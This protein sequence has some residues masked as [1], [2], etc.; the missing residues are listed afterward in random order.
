MLNEVVRFL[1]IKTLVIKKKYYELRLIKKNNEQINNL[2]TWR[3]PS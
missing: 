1:G 2:N 3:A